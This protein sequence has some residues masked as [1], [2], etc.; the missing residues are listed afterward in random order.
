M[1]AVTHRVQNFI[2][3]ALETKTAAFFITLFSTYMDMSVHVLPFYIVVLHG[4]HCE[5]VSRVLLAVKSYFFAYFR[6]LEEYIGWALGSK[7]ETAYDSVLN[8]M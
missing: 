8:I 1:T 7:S 3:T 5:S 2:K 4:W 6:L